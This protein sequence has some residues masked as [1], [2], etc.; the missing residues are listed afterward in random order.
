MS[1][2]REDDIPVNFE[3]VMHHDVPH[4]FNSLPWNLRILI[5]DRLR[6]TPSRFA[7]DHDM[8]IDVRLEWR[9]AIE[10]STVRREIVRNHVDRIEDILKAEPVR[11]HKGTASF[12]T[13][14]PNRPLS[15][16]SERTSTLM[17]KSS[18]KSIRRPP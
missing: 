4:P 3:I 9:I 6:G 2:S 8:A 18:L 12:R 7:N 15:A 11:P 14:C 13:I 5:L 10:S 17:P 1:G 16:P